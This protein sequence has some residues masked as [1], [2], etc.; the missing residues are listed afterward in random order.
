M[1]YSYAFSSVDSSVGCAPRGVTERSHQSHARTEGGMLSGDGA[2]E[3]GR[4]VLGRGLGW[5]LVCVW[6]RGRRAKRLEVGLRGGR[7]H[8]CKTELLPELLPK[9]HKTAPQNRAITPHN[10]SHNPQNRATA[11]HRTAPQK[12]APELHR[13]A[14]QNLAMTISVEILRAS[15]VLPD[16]PEPVMFWWFCYDFSRSKFCRD[17]SRYAPIAHLMSRFLGWYG[18]LCARTLRKKGF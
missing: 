4:G 1:S 6:G 8:A 14:P 7:A 18:T 16:R 12:S 13:A 9:L 2:G 5:G 15:E 3:G 11:L 17:T 10:C